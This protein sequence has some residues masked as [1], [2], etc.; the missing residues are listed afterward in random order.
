MQ[1]ASY[2]CSSRSEAY[3]EVKRLL[4]SSRCKYRCSNVLLHDALAH[5][6][7]GYQVHGTLNSGDCN[8]QRAW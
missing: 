5:M 8:G 6:V 4:F 2:Y 7:Q 1:Q 3:V